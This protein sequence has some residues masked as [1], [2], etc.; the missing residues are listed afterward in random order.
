[1][2]ILLIKNFLFFFSLIKTFIFFSKFCYRFPKNRTIR[3]LN[4]CN[5]KQWFFAYFC[6]IYTFFS[7]FYVLYNI[8]FINFMLYIQFSMFLM[9]YKTRFLLFFWNLCFSQKIFY[10]TFVEFATKKTR[11]GFLFSSALTKRTKQKVLWKVL[12][13]IWYYVS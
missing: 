1:M 2:K 5:W 9:F 12:P 10:W 4:F 3:K 7:H 13:K 8:Y 11:V 6:V